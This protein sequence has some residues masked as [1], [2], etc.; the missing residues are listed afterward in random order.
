M[1]TPASISLCLAC[2][3]KSKAN[4]D[5]ASRLGAEC[6]AHLKGQENKRSASHPT[7][8]EAKAGGACQAEVT[9]AFI[10][11]WNERRHAVA[12]NDRVRPKKALSR[13]TTSGG[14]S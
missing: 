13:V 10:P 2:R 11:Q 9:A 6:F 12:P 8:P 4:R 1:I 3:A 14:N 7:R 5:E